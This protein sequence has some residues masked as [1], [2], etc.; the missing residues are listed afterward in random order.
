M[1][2][3]PV[4]SHGTTCLLEYTGLISQS[5]ALEFKQIQLALSVGPLSLFYCIIKNEDNRAS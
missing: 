2:G 4:G 5:D 1:H 3:F